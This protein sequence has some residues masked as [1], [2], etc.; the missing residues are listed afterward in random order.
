LG[1]G[2]KKVFPAQRKMGHLLSR[3]Q[4]A[5]KKWVE[6]YAFLPPAP[7]YTKDHAR[8]FYVKTPKRDVACMWYGP[9]SYTHKIIL[10]AHGNACDIGKCDPWLQTLQEELKVPIVSFDYPG[11]GLS[12]P[13]EAPNTDGCLLSIRAVYEYLRGECRYEPHQIILYG[14]S[15]G[16]GPVLHL[17]SELAQVGV[18]LG[19]VL[20]QS[21]FSSS[22]STVSP[23]AAQTADLCYQDSAS[24][25]NIFR[26]LDC[27]QQVTCKGQ[28]LHGT[29][30]KIVPFDQAFQLA[31]RNAY[32]KLIPLEGL[33]HNDIEVNARRSV[34]T[35]LRSFI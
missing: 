32:F 20:L 29:L 28:I 34:F 17:A 15:L 1:T 6:S 33:G 27:I 9:K 31:S 24:N 18:D 4:Q 14:V 7:Y 23:F 16:T 21:P 8:L 3:C 25:P 13:K 11:Y 10:Y 5:P 30:D 12:S 35:A 19:G 26:N 22:V 2:R